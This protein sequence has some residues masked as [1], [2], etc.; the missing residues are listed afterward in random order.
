MTTPNPGWYPDPDPSNAGGQRFWDGRQWT[1]RSAPGVPRPTTEPTTPSPG[2]SPGPGGNHG[3]KI[4]LSIAAV[5]ILAVGI[6]SAFG[7]D[8]EE[9]DPDQASATSSELPAAT[10]TPAPAV[11]PSVAPRTP[12]RPAPTT[13][14]ATPAAGCLDAPGDVLA[15]INASLE[16]SGYELGSPAAYDDGDTLY[17]AG[18]I[19]EL[20]DG[21]IRSRDDVFAQQGP[22]LT[23]VTV[24]ARNESTLLDLHDELDL[25]FSDPGSQAA[26][27]CARTY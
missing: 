16:S 26:A 18:E 10:T 8:E 22:I 17:I 2:S 4:G 5:L 21:G 14:A 9:A 25:D 11:V 7:S 13:A 19:V 23:P 1:D 6:G 20:Q 27:D 12:V 3:L 15:A 24:T